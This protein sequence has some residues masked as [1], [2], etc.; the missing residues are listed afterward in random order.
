MTHAGDVVENPA[1]RETGRILTG[2]GAHREPRR[3]VMQTTR[4]AL[5]LSALGVTAAAAAPAAGA[6]TVTTDASGSL[7]VVSGPERNRIGLMDAGTG[8]GRIVVHEGQSTATVTSA[9]SACEQTDVY[10]VTCT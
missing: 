8:D 2:A 5:A 10:S 4:I 3:H 1:T 9:T 7:V 6:T